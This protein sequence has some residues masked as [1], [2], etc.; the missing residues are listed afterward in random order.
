MN[1]EGKVVMVKEKRLFENGTKKGNIAIRV[2][3][4]TFDWKETGLGRS[5]T[6]CQSCVRHHFNFLLS[7]YR[8]KSHA[9]HA[10]GE[11]SRSD[12]HRGLS[13]DIP[14]LRQRAFENVSA[15]SKMV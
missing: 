7:G 9:A 4:D 8:G 3:K 15:T 10:R 5:S 6:A 13:L 12:V 2:S 1:E 11:C 14:R